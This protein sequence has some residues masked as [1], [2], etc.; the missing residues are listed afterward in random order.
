M[1]PPNSVLDESILDDNSSQ[2]ATQP[3]NYSQ[4]SEAEDQS[5]SQE[6]KVPTLVT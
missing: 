6:D 5:M 4:D 1:G 3:L 2:R